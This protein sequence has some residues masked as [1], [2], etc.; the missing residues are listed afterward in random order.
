MSIVLG[1]LDTPSYNANFMF[2]EANQRFILK[3]T[4]ISQSDSES[5]NTALSLIAS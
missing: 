5:R 4:V 1:L 3:H 2:R